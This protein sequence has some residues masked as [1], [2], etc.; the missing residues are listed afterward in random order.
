MFLRGTWRQSTLVLY[1]CSGDRGKAPQNQGCS[2]HG[3]TK[4]LAAGAAAGKTAGGSQRIHRKIRRKNATL[5]STNEKSEKFEWT[6]E[7]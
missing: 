2:R 4:K 1:I 7:A 6:T 5:L 3:T